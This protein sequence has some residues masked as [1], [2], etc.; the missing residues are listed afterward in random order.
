M[1]RVLLQDVSVVKDAEEQNWKGGQGQQCG[2]GRSMTLLKFAEGKLT[3]EGSGVDGGAE[4]GA[5]RRT[6]P[7]C[8]GITRK[9]FISDH[10]TVDEN[11]NQ[12]VFSPDGGN[13]TAVGGMV[14][15]A[16]AFAIP[17]KH[18]SSILDTHPSVD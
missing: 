14:P 17:E 1:T 6:F 16:E 8:A 7:T 2:S 15:P 9:Y 10:E 18:T 4:E 12:A 13:Q 5:L 11:V 3:Q